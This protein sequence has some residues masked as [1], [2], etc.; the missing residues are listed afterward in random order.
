[1]TTPAPKVVPV[2][3][4]AELMPFSL[5]EADQMQVG[6]N[7]LNTEID[8]FFKEKDVTVDPAVYID[9]TTVYGTAHLPK[10]HVPYIQV[11]SAVKL[12]GVGYD[13]VVKLMEE[14]A[15]ESFP[16]FKVRVLTPKDVAAYK[17][18]Y[19]SAADT[20]AETS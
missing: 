17:A 20:G 9:T 19:A 15:P 18:R 7:D 10:D 6:I 8:T 1:M 2:L 5:M 12:V 16:Y 3:I 13:E 4:S 11:T 14:F